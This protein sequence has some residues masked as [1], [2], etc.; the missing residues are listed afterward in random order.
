M[1]EVLIL[2]V[3]I[4]IILIMTFLTISIEKYK[5]IKEEKRRGK[6]K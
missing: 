2:Q 6:E 3:L 1:N 4:V 5:D